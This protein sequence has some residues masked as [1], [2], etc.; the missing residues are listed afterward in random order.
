MGVGNGVKIGEKTEFCGRYPLTP[1][2]TRKKQGSTPGKEN[3]MSKKEKFPLYLS[4]EK[5]AILE[6]R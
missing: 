4:P 1:T 2:P 5:K 6:R 3:I